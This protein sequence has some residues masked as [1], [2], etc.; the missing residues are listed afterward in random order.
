MGFQSVNLERSELHSV[1]GRW[2]R[3]RGLQGRNSTCGLS[4]SQLERSELHSVCGRWMRSRGLKGANK[5][6][7]ELSFVKRRF[8]LLK[9]CAVRTLKCVGEVATAHKLL[10]IRAGRSGTPLATL[11][12]KAGS[13]VPVAHRNPPKHVVR[14]LVIDRG[15]RH[16]PPHQRP[17]QPRPP[18]P[19]ILIDVRPYRVPRC[20]ENRR[21]KTNLA[22]RQSPRNMSRSK[23]NHSTHHSRR[24]YTCQKQLETKLAKPSDPPLHVPSSICSASF[25]LPSQLATHNLLA[26][27]AALASSSCTRSS[28]KSHPPLQVSSSICSASSRGMWS[29]VAQAAALMRSAGA[30]PLSVSTRSV[31]AAGG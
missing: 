27:K 13:A 17:P 20:I 31:A 6:L 26:C 3:S 22:K 21:N 4:V 19:P 23:N 1:W 12:E 7:R 14:V 30:A 25:A 18:P 15:G 9:L 24:C 8:Q 28:K 29:V 11:G 5:E 10:D 2:M 16:Q